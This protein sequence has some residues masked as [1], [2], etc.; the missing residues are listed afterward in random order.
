[1]IYVSLLTRI[2]ISC[3]CLYKDS[4]LAGADIGDKLGLKYMPEV[5][6][7]PQM[8]LIWGVKRPIITESNY[9]ALD[10]DL[11]GLTYTY[12]HVLP[13]CITRFYQYL[14]AQCPRRHDI[15]HTITKLVP[16]CLEFSIKYH[17]RSQVWFI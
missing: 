9:Y 4:G 15:L 16:V 1:M 8:L 3:Y 10:N 13:G 7:S 17:S 14:P 6:S 11:S 2:R 5:D 12:T